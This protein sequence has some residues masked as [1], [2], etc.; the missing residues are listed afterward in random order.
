MSI[1]FD[2]TSF[3]SGELAPSLWGHTDLAKFATGASTMRNCFV[4]YRGGAYSR[5]GTRFVGMSKQRADLGDPAPR[6]INWQFN[7]NQG[8]TVEFGNFY[9]RFIFMGG[10]AL[11]AA[12]AITGVSNANP[13][14]VST[15]PTA[16]G[17]SAGDWVAINGVN[18]P[19]Q[20]NGNTYQI[21]S[22]TTT[23][24][25]I[26][27]TT[28]YLPINS[29]AWPPYVSAG[30]VARVYTI[31][32]PYA[33]TD[34]PLL[35]YTQSADVMSLT[36]T[37]Y[38]P[39]DLERLG[40]TNWVLAPTNFGVDIAAPAGATA[41][42]TVQ[43]S[44][45]SSPPTLPAAYAYE[46]TAVSALDGQESQPSPIANI[47]N[48]VDMAETAGS[49]IINWNAVIGVGFYQVYRAPTSYNTDP[50]NPN[51]ALPVPVGAF[52]GLVGSSFGTQFVD[53]NIIP[54]FS[55]SPPQHQDPF[56]P[57]QVLEITVTA[58]SV[59]WTTA[60]VGITS[61]TGTGFVGE[62]VIS[63]AAIVAVIVL[64]PG[65]NYLPGD[66]VTFTGD[67][68]S[69]SATLVVGPTTG[70]YPG[71]V[72]YFQQRR[73]YA[74]TINQPDTYFASQTG[75]FT[76][77]DVS[78]PVSDSDALEGTPWSEKIDGIQWML[79]MPLGLL[80]F[81]GSGVWQVGAPGA[82]ASSPASI[83]PANQIAVPQ[84]SIGCSAQLPPIRVN[85][86]VLYFQ[87]KGYSV[88]DLTYQIFFNIYA[89]T[90]ISWPSS[91]LL[92]SYTAEQWCYCDE[93]WRIV[94][95]VRNDGILLSLTYLK[96]QEVAGWARHDTQGQVRSVCSVT[97]PPVDALYLVVER[98][99]STSLTGYF[100][101]RMDNR[102]WQGVEDTWAVDA[103]VGSVLVNPAAVLWATSASGPV[104]FTA[105]APVFVPG[106]VGMVLRS[107]GGIAVISQYLSDQLVNGTWVYPCQ[108]LVPNYPTPVPIKQAAGAWSLAPPLTQVFGLLHLM[109]E[110]VV[111]L[112]DGVPIGPFTVSVDG[113]VTLPFPASN[114]RLGLA[115]TAQVQSLYLE[116]GT[117][118]TVQGRRKSIFAVTARFEASSPSQVGTNQ[119]DTS[120]I[121][122]PGL[123]DVW[124][125]LPQASAANVQPMPTAAYTTPGGA[126]AQPLFTGDQRVLVTSVW[127]KPGQAA[128]QQTLPMPLN[129]LALIPEV[130][131]G[132]EPED[133]IQPRPRQ[134]PAQERQ[135]RAA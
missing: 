82:F 57:G 41:T 84:S 43:P 9:C 101:E 65:Q 123:F 50:G 96:E 130:L 133:K 113:G 109:G 125:N 77:F 31:A 14:S 20:I 83:T 35:K 94:W 99:R 2:K 38:P 98:L 8:Y 74:Q 107:G 102:L 120:A 34:L 52:F 13:C 128:V 108:Q 5:A 79:S 47:V 45:A 114:V 3:A 63:S 126:M 104:Q 86:D 122:P 23:S 66:T 40:P 100:I 78:N 4:G 11:E 55:Q 10:F 103:A 33:A 27:D 67:G 22:A 15:A 7:N 119:P 93:P 39:Y 42:A 62:V 106:D 132:D 37:S 12:V 111:G 68:T 51:D 87:S 56:A 91:H 54:D 36:H 80:T 69:A 64:N 121:S 110:Q 44:G 81:T 17:Y 124:P 95:T 1:P 60:A 90:D 32:S 25:T 21:I 46:V 30:N 135:R 18:G 92:T 97:E 131:P 75:H 61:G 85:W 118:P 127:A 117:Q 70:T 112:A 28:N 24:F 116:T 115:F 29:T 16:H 88:R 71:V 48:G 105:L 26:E 134:P 58:S 89:G 19:P 59:D 76:N 49:N 6:I 53:S 73:F 72:S 129:L